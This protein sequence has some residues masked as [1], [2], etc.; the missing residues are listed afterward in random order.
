MKLKEILNKFLVTLGY[1][2]IAIL[3][4]VIGFF[5]YRRKRGRKVNYE[6][7]GDVVDSLPN[8]DAVRERIN[9][10]GTSTGNSGGRK[11]DD[12][13]AGRDIHGKSAA[14]G[15]PGVLTRWVDSAK[16]MGVSGTQKV[17]RIS[18][19]GSDKGTGDTD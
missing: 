13:G 3:S 18:N 5:L 8:A 12:A 10:F 9:D 19:S 14:G 11:S 7:P 16:R 4:G 1:L 2:F 6:N 17:V 15:N